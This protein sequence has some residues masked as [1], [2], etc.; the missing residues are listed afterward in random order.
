MDN[1]N[2]ESLF[3]QR[4]QLM[5]SVANISPLRVYSFLMSKPGQ[6]EPIS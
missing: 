4:K 6:A 3:M 5:S 2:R 1:S